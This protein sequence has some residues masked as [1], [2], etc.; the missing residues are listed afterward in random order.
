MSR[1]TLLVCGATAT[2]AV[3]ACAAPPG[4][5]RVSILDDPE[6]L[7]V[8]AESPVLRFDGAGG[9]L[10]AG[11]GWTRHRARERDG[12][13][14]SIARGARSLLYFPPQSGPRELLLDCRA[15]P[16]PGRTEVAVRLLIDGKERDR[17]I[18]P[19]AWT[20]VRLSFGDASLDRGLQR[21]ELRFE[22]DEAPV[23]PTA[24]PVEPRWARCHTVAV[25]E[26]GSEPADADDASSLLAWPVPARSS[27]DVGL[28]LAALPDGTELVATLVARDGSRQRLDR[29][30]ATVAGERRVGF[31]NPSP[32]PAE[33]RLSASRGGGPLRT[34]PKLRW[35]RSGDGVVRGQ[36]PDLYLYVVDTLRADAFS[37]GWGRAIPELD[38]WRRESITF[39]HAWSPSSWTLPAM[40]SL[41]TG[42]AIATHGLRNGGTRL[43]TSSGP[44]LAESL[45]DAGYRTLGLSQS[46]VVGPRFGLDRGFEE[47]VL[48]DQINGDE[49]RA[50]ELRRFLRQ[51]LVHEAPAEQ[52]LFVL[53]H[54]VEPHGPYTSEPGPAGTA[55]ER[56]DMA[57]LRNPD[58]AR[59]ADLLRLASSLYQGEAR[60]AAIQFL[61]LVEMLRGLD[62][63]DR[64]AILFVAD[65]GEEFG[66][67]GGF[68]HGRT[69]RSEQ[70]RVPALLKLPGGE[71]AGV[72]VASGIAS[73]D[74]VATLAELAGVASPEGAFA[75]SRSLLGE[76]RRG[77]VRPRAIPLELDVAPSEEY[78]EIGL[79]ALLLGDLQCERDLLGHDRW[80][81][82]TSA[83]SY[84]RVDMPVGA[85]IASADDTPEARRC[86]EQLERRMAEERRTPAGPGDAVSEEERAGLRA[87]GYIR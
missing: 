13:T 5:V 61:R 53:L 23:P 41:L 45:R 56:L 19:E 81:R 59:D 64:A 49:H 87:L 73:P 39:E 25:L 33:V 21:A 18:F 43:G 32:F 74:L 51:W 83:W 34:A 72:S 44:T 54:T 57:Q 36:R 58:A 30:Q 67:R 27:G 76:L 63:Y 47:F 40:A 26:P 4:E 8:D 12:L 15:V 35:T 52:P 2:A 42:Q 50:Q 86:R 75:D 10:L 17:G 66:E 37:A 84:W 28:D 78:A 77:A 29:W 31:E 6:V 79:R 1:K 71:L 65:H 9:S 11:E 22:G 14:T 38:A 20:R 60:V 3:L 48:S 62:R 24:D 46:W 16:A 69:L 70:T 80:G 85:E 7:T 82:P 68:E 55:R